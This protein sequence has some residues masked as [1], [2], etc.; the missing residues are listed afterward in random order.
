MIPGHPE[1]KRQPHPS[2]QSPGEGRSGA[3]TSGDAGRSRPVSSESGH[4][5]DHQ[6]S[7]A[8]FLNYQTGTAGSVSKGR[9][10]R[11]A[12][13]SNSWLL[14]NR[15]AQF[16]SVRFCIRTREEGGG[17][18]LAQSRE[19][20]PRFPTLRLPEGFGLSPWFGPHKAPSRGLVPSGLRELTPAIN[21]P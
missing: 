21:H 20:R 8:L 19:L 4:G 2:P 7:K 13:M 18:F 1:E 15:G 9:L 12:E 10:G 16:V 5:P 11:S 17:S 14:A 3:G 6:W